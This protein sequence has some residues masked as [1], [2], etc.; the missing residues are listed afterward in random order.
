MIIVYVKP[1]CISCRYTKK[2]L[3]QHN[4]PFTEVDVSVREEDAKG[5]WDNGFRELPVVQT[6][7]GAWSGYRRDK[8]QALVTKTEHE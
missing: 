2:F 3:M 4:I 8:L 7:D 5:L 6:T 1:D